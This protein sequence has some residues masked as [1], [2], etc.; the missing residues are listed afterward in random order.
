MK[1]VMVAGVGCTQFGKFPDTRLRDLVADAVALALSDARA[2]ASQVEAV[3][4]G[5]AAAGLLTGQEMIRGQVE[6]QETGIEGVPVFNVENACAS[7]STALH[8]AWQSVI[9]GRHELVLAVGAE[10]MSGVSKEGVFRALTA[11]LDV[12]TLDFESGALETRSPFMDVYARMAEHYQAASGATA[13]D[14]ALVAR[15]N[16]RNGSGNPIAQYGQDLSLEEVLESRRIAGPLTLYMCSGIGDGAVAAVVCSPERAR[17]LAAPAVAIAASVVL[18][19][20][21]DG[22]GGGAVARAATDAYQMAGIEPRD[23]DVVEVHDAVAPAELMAIEE[24]GLA[25]PGGGPDYVRSGASAIGGSCPVNPSGG[26]LARG[27]PIGATGLA[28]IYELALQL[29]GQAGS[30]Q[31]AGARVALAQN[32]GGYLNGDIGAEAIHIL[33]G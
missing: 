31:V 27:H 22:R 18:S 4:F 26:L 7:A 16:H 29:R 25:S 28:Q 19:G 10:K 13:R 17:T 14:F 20:Q 9:A 12:E 11:A 21:R 1:Q 15:K 32:G 24:L 6:L 8:L 33:M 3:F 5:N 30:R 2:E 23:V